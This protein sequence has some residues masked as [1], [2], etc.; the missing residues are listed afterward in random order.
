MTIREIL[1]N[2]E[3][4]LDEDV[5]TLEQGVVNARE[6]AKQN[7]QAYM[8]KDG[9]EGPGTIVVFSEHFITMF[10]TADSNECM[11]RMS[12]KEKELYW[13][14]I[15][16]QS[17]VNQLIMDNPT[18]TDQQI[19]DQ[20]LIDYEAADNYD[21]PELVVRKLSDWAYAETLEFE[22]DACFTTMHTWE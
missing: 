19:D 17:I 7:N 22:E 12:K 2:K 16:Y 9:V 15:T 8:L 4:S 20:A 18:W 21:T 6:L 1:L 3:T 5:P 13:D 14:Y 10:R 11:S